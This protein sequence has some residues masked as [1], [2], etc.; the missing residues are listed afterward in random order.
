MALKGHFLA[1]SASTRKAVVNKSCLD[2]CMA[3]CV[4]VAITVKGKIN[5][6][7]ECIIQD[8]VDG[9]LVKHSEG[10]SHRLY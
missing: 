10:T 4:I 6:V 9:G 8:V 2:M 1:Y 7:D 3:D 5:W